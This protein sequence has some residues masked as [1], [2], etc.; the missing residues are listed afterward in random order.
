MAIPPSARTTVRRLAER[1][2]Y[3]PVTVAAI[4]DEALACHVGFVRD[5]TPSVIPMLHARDGATLYLHGSPASALLRS[6]RSGEEICVA[7]TLVDGIVM[8]RAPFHSSMNYR[9][10]VVYGTPRI[11]EDEKEKRRALEVLTEHVSRGRWEDSRRPTAQE[12]KSTLVVALPL[13]EASA[14]I[15]T[16]PP[17]D[18]E[19]DHAL[20]IWAGVIPL[21][22][23]AGEPIDDPRLAGGVRLPSYL[24]G[25]GRP[26]T[27]R[28]L[29]SEELEAGLEEIRRSPHDEG[30][31]ELIIRRPAE[32]EREVLT[33]AELDTTVGVVGDNW[34]TRGS[35]STPDG[36]AHPDMQLNVMNARVARLVALSR[37][38]WPLAGDQ[39]Y[40]DLD[41]SV[42]NLPAGTRLA[43]GSAI[44]EVTAVPH[45]GCGKFVRRFGKAAHQFVNSPLGREMRLRGLNARVVRSGEVRIRDT[46]RK[47]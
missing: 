42:D 11:V 39:L 40:V 10:V 2:E 32:N 12:I 41:L 36:R 5:A 6:M 25:Y 45:T 35:T 31:V 46:I 20:P 26:Q 8:A 22:L 16:G 3:D 17:H 15:R 47:V 19:E 4:V 1:G 44:I 9:S 29:N 21:R 13:D 24:S 28:H 38:R 33:V 18:D 43:V 30:V 7:I 34:L 23:H 27:V 37:D 14:K